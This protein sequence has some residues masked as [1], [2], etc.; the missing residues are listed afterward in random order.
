MGLLVMEAHVLKSQEDRSKYD[1]EDLTFIRVN[2]LYI[3]MRATTR[4]GRT[5]GPTST[6]AVLFAYSAPTGRVRSVSL[7]G[8]CTCDGGT[9]RSTR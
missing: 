9:P 4:N 1:D 6:L 2:V 7:C 5:I 8:N 3:E